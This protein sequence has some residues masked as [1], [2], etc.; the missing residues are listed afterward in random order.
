[1]IFSVYDN[2]SKLFDYYEAPG[3]PSHYGARGQKYRAL[4]QRG[5]LGEVGVVPEALGMV[6]PSNA[7]KVG[8][9]VEA[10]GMIATRGGVN[11]G[12]GG[13]ASVDGLGGLGE[14]EPATPHHGFVHVVGAAVIASVVGV[15]VQRWMNKKK[16]RG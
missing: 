13:Y 11:G 12:G 5:G 9:G 6:L 1:M 16:R 10:R 8:S 3:N 15:F 14:V 2:A 7:V 4:S